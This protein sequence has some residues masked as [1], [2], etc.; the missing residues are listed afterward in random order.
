MTGWRMR[1]W[2]S[3]TATPNLIQ[4][5]KTSAKDRLMGRQHKLL[6]RVLSGTADRI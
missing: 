2:T 6:E 3:R 4:S 5:Q 1:A